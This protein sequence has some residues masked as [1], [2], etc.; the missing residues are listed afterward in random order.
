MLLLPALLLPALLLAEAALAQQRPARPPPRPPAATPPAPAP[1]PAPAPGPLQRRFTVAELGMAEGAGFDATGRDILFPL[2]RGLPIT[3]ARL[4]FVVD[5]ASAF[6]ARHAVEVAVNGRVLGSLAFAEGTQ[7]LAFDAVLPPE[8]LARSPEALRVSIRLLEQPFGSGGTASVTAASYLAVAVPEGVLPSVAAMFQLLPNR[9]QVLAP[10]GPLTPADAAAALRIGLALAATGREVH[11]TG[12]SPP[13]PVP[14]P[15]GQRLWETGAVQ[16]GAAADGATVLRVGDVPVLA[17]GGP[18]P[19][20]A[21][22]LL[23]GP[24]RAAGATPALEVGALRA[25]VPPNAPLPFADLLGTLAPQ[26]G[27]RAAW[28]LRFSTRDLPPGTQPEALEVALRA[29]PGSRAVASVVLNDVVL[30]A[31]TLPADGRGLLSLSIPPSLIALDNRID[32]S[33]HRQPGPGQAVVGGPAQLLPESLLRLGPAGPPAE[34]LALPP[35]FAEGLEVLID[36]PGGSL[37]IAVL[38]TALWVMRPL[39]PAGAPIRV[40]P[41]EPDS[42]PRPVGA[43]LAITEVPPEGSAPAMRFEPGRVLLRDGAGQPLLDLGSVERM[44]VA[45]LVAAEGRPGLWLHLPA[46]LPALPN[47]APRLDRGDIALLDAQGVA[48]AWNSVRQ[49]VSQLGTVV[50]PA[51]ERSLVLVW[52][53]WV[54]G[55]LWFAGFAL[56]AYAFANPRRPAAG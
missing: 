22:R 53:P 49:P 44:M 28:S 31:A 45:Q 39:V 34:F 42:P 27:V 43:F 1:A 47:A 41:V 37:P 5:L 48:L 52:R 32:V 40:T 24:W 25:T 56:V 11:I 14:G 6:Q 50:M 8:D 12:G 51:E 54:A 9:V 4:S 26:E 19:E 3:L 17:L 33:L 20:R 36:A 46:A 16:L 2:P 23:E 55:G 15:G 38:N 35:R 29:P 18:A 21:A 7:R 30:G 13:G 10:P